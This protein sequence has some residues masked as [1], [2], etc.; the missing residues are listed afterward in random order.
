[1]GLQAL[2]GVPRT[3]T[4]T[5]DTTGR[6]VQFDALS[7]WLDIKADAALDLF[8]SQADF[9]NGVNA[10][11]VDGGERF[12]LPVEDRGVWMQGVGGD[13]NVRMTVIHRKG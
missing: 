2:G 4:F 5:I 13:V 11:R 6:F 8:W 10:H 7:M 1:M 12:S 9:D 3:R